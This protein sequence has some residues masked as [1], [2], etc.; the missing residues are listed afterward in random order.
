M[1]AYR[2]GAGAVVLAVAT[3]W[4]SDALA[5]GDEGSDEGVEHTVIVGVGG[6]AELELRDGAVHPGVNLMIEWDAVESWLEF[7][8]GASVLAADRGIEAP[9]DLLVKKPFRLT[10]RA[11]LMLAIGPEVVP[12]SNPT[13]KATYVGGEVALDFMFWPWQRHVGLWVEPEYDFVFRDG[14]S[15]GLGSTGGVLFGW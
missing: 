10:R 1:N 15:H 13:T 6:A 7:E 4:S 12:V 11:E 2:T 9:I 5:E 14:V 3:A 8:V